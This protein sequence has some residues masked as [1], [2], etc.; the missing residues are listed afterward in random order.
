MKKTVVLGA[1]LNPARASNTAMKMLTERNIEAVPI[2]LKEGELYGEKIL[3]GKPEIED[4]HT[5]SL[6]MNPKRQEDFYDYI[7][8]LKPERIIFNPGTENPFFEEKAKAEGVET[9]EACTLVM[10]STQQF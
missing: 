3:R 10:L 9:V 6:Y 2:G 5:V 8:S 1:S 7:L 4:V